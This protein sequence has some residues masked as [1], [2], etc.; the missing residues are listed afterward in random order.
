MLLNNAIS[1]GVGFIPLVGDVILAVYKA[2]SR[3]AALLEEFLRV[4][5][6]GCLD[7]SAAGGMAQAGG[8]S[9][10]LAAPALIIASTA[11]AGPSTLDDPKKK[12]SKQWFSSSAKSG[13]ETL[14]ASDV[15]QVKPGAG[16]TG[17]EL[18]L[19]MKDPEAAAAAVSAHVGKSGVESSTAS[20]SG[21]ASGAGAGKTSGAATLGVEGTSSSSKKPSLSSSSKFSFFGSRSKKASTS[22]AAKDRGSGKFVEHLDA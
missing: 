5:G 10:G 14:T 13:K 1:T 22:T 4:R 21:H 9:V 19:V 17:S 6:E 2:N 16:M 18:Q 12:T 3:N 7:M 11:V 8:S 15:Q 20:S